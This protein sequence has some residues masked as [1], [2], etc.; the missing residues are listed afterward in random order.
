MTLFVLYL[1]ATT[2]CALCAYRVAAGRCALIEKASYYRSAVQ[3]GIIFA[4]A[5][6]AISGAILLV[7]LLATAEKQ[8]LVDDLIHASN[9][10]LTVYVPYAV[11]V[12][13]T[14]TL[15]LIPSTDIRAAT[16]VMILGPMT[17]LRPI[18]EIAGVLYGV[19]P[20]RLSQTRWLGGT[21]L[22]LMFTVQWMLECHYST[23]D[24]QPASPSPR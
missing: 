23:L 10:M 21:T 5:G 4:Q 8:V 22:V 6:C 14:L 15:R 16:S 11:L 18:V 19:V 24:Q 9:R 2:D 3:R 12:L 7:M 13:G 17:A 20:A 1:L